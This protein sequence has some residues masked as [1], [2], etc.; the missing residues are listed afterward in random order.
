MSL[1]KISIPSKTFLWGEYS[2]LIGGSAGLLT[3]GPYFELQIGISKNEN[4]KKGFS[5]S[6]N[7]LNSFSENTM[8]AS[9]GD[10][11]LEHLFHPHSP[12]GKTLKFSQAEL[13]AM[14]CSFFDPHHLSGGFGRS[15]AEWISAKFLNLLFIEKT[16]RASWMEDFLQTHSK[17]ASMGFNHLNDLKN[18]VLEEWWTEYR[19]LFQ[20][21]KKQPSGYDLL[22][23]LKNTH[24][25][26]RSGHLPQVSV[27]YGNN[28]APHIL[29]NAPLSL[30]LE[31]LIFKTAQKIKTHEHLQSLEP[32]PL[33]ENLRDL[34]EDVTGSYMKGH[35][36]GFLVALKTFDKALKEFGFQCLESRTYCET[37]Q[38]LPGVFHARGCGALGADVIAVFCEAGHGE[39]LKN[40]IAQTTDLIFI[41]DTRGID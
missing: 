2:A 35:L 24:I 34:S 4:L 16:E 25:E 15:T 32:I 9:K 23:Q 30:N 18:D 20:D 37:I 31:I 26:I 39:S 1:S 8:N 11:G 33:L 17:T 41:A 36:H 13:L 28:E 22:A 6:K 12:A 40:E 5:A 21:L 10:S 27:I 19:A 7:S 14:N 38:T 29:Q 3:H